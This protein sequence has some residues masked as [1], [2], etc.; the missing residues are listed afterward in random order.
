MNGSHSPTKGLD[1]KLHGKRYLKKHNRKPL[2]EGGVTLS[3]DLTKATNRK[4]EAS[5][6][7]MS[8]HFLQNKQIS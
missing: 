7:R 3:E 6:K 8:H 1:I 5:R 4:N 2:P